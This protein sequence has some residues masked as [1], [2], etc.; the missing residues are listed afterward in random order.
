MRS[1]AG[2][3]R[4]EISRC[5]Q[6]HRSAGNVFS[7]FSQCRNLNQKEVEKVKK[8]TM[9]LCQLDLAHFD[10]FIWPPCGTKRSPVPLSALGGPGRSEA[11]RRVFCGASR[12][13]RRPGLP[14]A[15]DQN[16]GCGTLPSGSNT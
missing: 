1:A 6:K 16:I 12:A 11:L 9:S 2:F 10:T 13:E 8:D 4:K 14:R 3:G 5:E 7:T 15:S